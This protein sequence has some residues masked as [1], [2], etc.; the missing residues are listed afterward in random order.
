[1]LTLEGCVPPCQ[2]NPASSGNLE[3][4]PLET[5][6]FRAQTTSI[7]PDPHYKLCLVL[8]KRGGRV[9]PPL[10]STALGP[11]EGM[12]GGGLAS[13]GARLVPDHGVALL[14]AGIAIAVTVAGLELRW[15]RKHIMASSGPSGLMRTR[16][17]RMARGRQGRT[18][19]KQSGRSPGR[20]KAWVSGGGSS[21]AVRS[22]SEPLP[23]TTSKV[24]GR[25]NVGGLGG[26]E[27]VG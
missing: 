19:G 2:Q 4:R 10:R 15:K 26:S 13:L 1:M 7:H 9:D 20:G 16:R 8:G 22:R 5:R 6:T 14:F 21:R 18:Q 27:H 24:L 23:T 12:A 3:R 25:D 11:A 17:V